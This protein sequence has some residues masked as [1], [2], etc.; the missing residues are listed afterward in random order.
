[1]YCCLPVCTTEIVSLHVLV[2]T[3]HAAPLKSWLHDVHVLHDAQESMKSMKQL[4]FCGATKA[5]D[6]VAHNQ[7][8]VSTH[9]VMVLR[10][11]I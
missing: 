7:L 2:H 9:F 8:Q 6:D 4:M 1:M 5:V 3:S 10:D 11:R